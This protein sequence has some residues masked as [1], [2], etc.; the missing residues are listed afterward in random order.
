MSYS[1]SST[2]NEQ[3]IREI[4]KEHNIYIIIIGHVSIVVLPTT[5]TLA[6]GIFPMIQ[7]CKEM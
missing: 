6:G 4:R 5:S 1:N 2:W 3:I 7:W